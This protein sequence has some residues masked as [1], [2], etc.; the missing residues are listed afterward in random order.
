MSKLRTMMAAGL[1]MGLTLALGRTDGV[2]SASQRRAQRPPA[3][4]H[5]D[6]RS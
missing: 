4:R 3:G 5:A 1:L 2:R 6:G